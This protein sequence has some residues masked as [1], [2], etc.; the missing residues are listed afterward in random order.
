MIIGRS[1]F[2][3]FLLLLFAAALVGGCQLIRGDRE[4]RLST[5]RVHVEAIPGSNAFS[6]TVP[7]Y[8]ERPVL[9][10]VDKTP[11]LTEANVT[12]AKVVE[13]RDGFALE[14]QFDRRGTWLLESYTTINPGKHLA[15]F[16]EFGE[17]F[18]RDARW[19][20][21]PI[22]EKRISK[23]VL[24]FTPDASREEAEQIA[25]GLNNVARQN[26]MKSRW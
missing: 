20:A 11:F 26:Q 6:S 12:G 10:P 22:I 24:T 18:F 4:K 21:A 14:I 9:I 7:I 25:L 1:R 3:I 5:L 23:G 13:G 2:N 16:S 8:R 15:I 19:L 17:K